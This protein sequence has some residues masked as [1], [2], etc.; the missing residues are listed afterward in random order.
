MNERSPLG[1]MAVSKLRALCISEREEGRVAERRELLLLLSLQ[2]ANTQTPAAFRRNAGKR[3]RKRKNADR[4]HV[5]VN[6]LLLNGKI[7]T[8]FLFFLLLILLLKA[9]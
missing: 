7:K 9:L 2:P 6:I 8:L 3:K 5:S 4:A 1:K